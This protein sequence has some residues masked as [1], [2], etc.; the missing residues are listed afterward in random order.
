MP[1]K[2]RAQWFLDGEACPKCEQIHDQ[3]KC[4]GHRKSDGEPCGRSHKP[5]ATSCHIH[6]S[7]TEAAKAKAAGRLVEAEV[8][9]F[10]E[11]R[12]TP[13]KIDHRVALE[14][15]MAWISALSTILRQELATLTREEFLSGDHPLI[16][17][18]RDADLEQLRVIELCDKAGLTQQRIEEM[19]QVGGTV[20]LSM[21][22]LVGFIVAWLVS[23]RGVPEQ[24][25]LDLEAAGPN[26]LR[27]ALMILDPT[28]QLPGGN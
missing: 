1:R 2:P 26:F 3:A 16:K 9:G 5:G 10:L 25:P 11:S 23:Q 12:G 4:S 8:R 6:G 7:A 21:K 18:R 20:A 13:V 15:Y 19:K 28:Q 14:Q 17:L 22:A 24:V 27:Q